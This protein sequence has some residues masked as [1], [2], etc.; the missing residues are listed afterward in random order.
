[1]CKAVW[2]IYIWIICELNWNRARLVYCKWSDTVPL[3]RRVHVKGPL[4]DSGPLEAAYDEG[5]WLRPL[6]LHQLTFC[7]SQSEGQ[8]CHRVQLTHIW[9]LNNTKSE[10]LGND[11]TNASVS[12]RSVS[13]CR[14]W[15]RLWYDMMLYLLFICRCRFLRW[16]PV[17]QLNS[18]WCRQGNNT[19]L[20]TYCTVKYI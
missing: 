3:I 12:R 5:V 13:T 1:M 8:C 16:F 9:C 20:N 10:K 6:C 2:I 7:N 18:R 14:V 19:G 17:L 11:L 4:D 15:L